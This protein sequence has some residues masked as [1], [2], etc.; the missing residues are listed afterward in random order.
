MK[1]QKADR[2]SAIEALKLLAMVLIIFSHA[3]PASAPT[4]G[5]QLMALE[6][7]T[8]SK[9]RFLI[10]LLQYGG[11]IGNA[12]FL[13]SSAWFLVGSRTAKPR[14]MLYMAADT[15]TISVAFLAVFLLCG[16]PI[17][18]AEALRQF[19]PMTFGA[20]WYVICYLMFYAIHP[21]LNMVL[22]TLDRKKLLALNIV[23]AL[24]YCGVGMFRS[25]YYY[26]KFIGFICV[27]FFTAYWKLYIPRDVLSVKKSLLGCLCSGAGL[28]ALVLLTNLLG[29]RISYFSYKLTM[30]NNFMNPL[31]LLTA[32]FALDLA[33]RVQF[34]SKAVNYLSSI[35]M[36]IYIVHG[37]RLVMDH[38]K[39]DA[40]LYILK[41]YTYRYQLL[42]VLLCGIIL[43][44]GGTVIS[45]L[46]KE[47]LQR[48]VHRFCD[49]LDAK[50]QSK[51]SLWLEK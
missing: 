44:V 39:Q 31:I 19:F 50:I 38:L 21:V 24:M 34:H 37:N 11:Q 46:Y 17:G 5:E 8:Q 14:K 48:L 40:F 18:R 15:F 10:N 9:Q 16:Y 13:V 32:F 41:T 22:D 4:P 20:N 2:N 47:T 26:N 7:V 33:M 6:Q 49:T 27:F 25:A 12:V 36:I 3:M 42:W 1:L 29:L 28:A 30:W 35:T 45:I 51:W 23:L 43:L